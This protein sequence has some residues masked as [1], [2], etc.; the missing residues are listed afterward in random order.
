MLNA[1]RSIE[2][3][4]DPSHIRTI[5]FRSSSHLPASVGSELMNPMM[6]KPAPTGS[7]TCTKSGLMHLQQEV[8]AV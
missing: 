5:S 4:V 7:I 1:D 6:L 8:E 2:Q 3:Q